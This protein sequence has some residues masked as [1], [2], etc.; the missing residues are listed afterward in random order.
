MADW[1]LASEDLDD[2][3]LGCAMLGSGGGGDPHY[4]VTLLRAML[5]RGATIRIIDP[6][7]LSDDDIAVNVGYVG[8]P[9]TLIEKLIADREIVAGIEA[10]QTRLPAPLRA[11]I[12]SEIGGFNGLVPLIAGGLTGLPVI[13]ADGMGRAFPRSDQVAFAIYGHSATPTVVSG[14]RGEA[15][16]IESGSCDRVEMLVRALSVAMGSKCFAVDYPLSGRDIRAHAV[17]RTVSL[18]RGIGADIRAAAGDAH[19]P[20]A[21]LSESLRVRRGIDCLLLI[22]GIVMG[23]EHGTDGGFDVGSAIVKEPGSGGRAVTLDFQNEFLVA[24]QDGAPLVST[25]DIISVVDSDTLTPITSDAIR[26]G[27]RVKVI[28][29]SAPL[30]MRSARALASVGPRAFGYA[31]DYRPISGGGGDR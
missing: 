12:A 15:I 3:A 22:D 19:D 11:L 1:Y 24:W 18:A 23:R 4:A 2:L 26:Y 6:G 30:L 7:A 13:D 25:P 17:P 9:F 31:F 16:V 14:E 10:M 8:A 5:A 21:A 28:A 27:Q 29:L 20:F